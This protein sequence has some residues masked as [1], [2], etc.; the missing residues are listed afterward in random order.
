M[1]D[2]QLSSCRGNILVL[3]RVWDLPVRI[4]HGLV[5]MLVALSWITAGNGWLGSHKI[6]GYAILT[7]VI[8]R[9]YWGVCGS[10]TAQF[11]HFL[12]SPKAVIR[13]VCAPRPREKHAFLGHNPLGGWSVIAL[14]LALLL[15]VGLGLFSVDVDGLESGPFSTHVSFETGRRIAA[16]HGI[17]FN[18]L[19][20]LICL[21]VAAV[22]VHLLFERN[23]L[24]VPMLTGIK[25]VPCTQAQ[26]VSFAGPW[27]ALVGLAASILLMVVLVYAL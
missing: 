21:H 23:N 2:K 5:V 22:L 8:F 12:Y 27:R 18:I 3:M 7:L 1:A 13:Y 15:Q 20:V 10:S 17:G 4:V 14:L 6:S 11:A 19:L 9:I 24:I 16:L 25:R 26:S